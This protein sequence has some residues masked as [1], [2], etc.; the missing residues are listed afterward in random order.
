MR[1]LQKQGY[2]NLFSKSSRELDLRDSLAVGKYFNEIRPEY[3]FFAAGT[4]GGI[5]ANMNYP[6]D[7]IYDNLAMVTNVVH[8]SRETGIKKL[9]NFASNCVYPKDCLQPMKEE[10]ILTGQ[11]EETN[12]PYAVAKIAGIELCFSFN[13]QYKTDYIVLLPANLFGVGDNYDLEK[14]H[15]VAALLRKI[16]EAKLRQDKEV[17]LW[18]T[19][20][21]R[22]ELLSSDS[23]ADAALHFMNNFSG[24]ETINIGSGA[25]LT[26]REIASIVNEIVGYDGRIVFDSSK[27][28]GVSRK[29]LDISRAKSLGWI[30]KSD[31]K[32]DLAIAY[33]D[34]VANYSEY[35]R[36]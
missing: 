4:V 24:S 5:V 34:L 35:C 9:L 32:H 7:F 13:R 36:K 33:Q 22:R 23:V 15:L 17:I 25:D 10:F 12:K 19:G 27:P 20:N 26:V 18:G 11:L 3:V 29:L 31:I 16:H 28:D 1:G 21:P 2:R 14:S 30:L 8:A 6:A